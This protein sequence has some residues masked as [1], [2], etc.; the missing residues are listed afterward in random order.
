[1]SG[2]RA[3][4]VGLSLH[5]RFDRYKRTTKRRNVLIKSGLKRLRVRNIFADTLQQTHLNQHQTRNGGT[6]VRGVSFSE[7]C[8]ASWRLMRCPTTRKAILA[9]LCLNPK[10][11]A[12]SECW[13]LSD[14]N[15]FAFASRLVQ[16]GKVTRVTNDARSWSDRE[17]AAIY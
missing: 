11:A 14:E 5:R 6:E 13:R 10:T 3:V 4:K 8:S 17:R 1:M 15:C 12:L 7:D 16:P 2:K 9:K